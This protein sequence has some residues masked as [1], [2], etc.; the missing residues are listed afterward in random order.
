M[1]TFVLDASVTVAW[2]LDKQ[3][4]EAEKAF[5]LL[6]GRQV[7][8][9]GLWHLETRNS[10]IVEMRRKKLTVGWYSEQADTLSKL[11]AHTDYRPDLDA[12]FKLA[13]KRNLTFYDAVYLE[14]AKRHN[15]PLATFDKAMARGA[16]AEGLTLIC[17][18]SF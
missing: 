15:V 7:L 5:T 6:K 18:K 10:L 2:L 11:P 12:A 3:N 4:P 8:V 1:R 16:A 14:L 9:P 13:A 17:K